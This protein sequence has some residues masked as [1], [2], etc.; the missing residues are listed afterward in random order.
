MTAPEWKRP[1]S[2]E[3]SSNIALHNEA[4]DR[5]HGKFDEKQIVTVFVG[6]FSKPSRHCNILVHG[7]CACATRESDATCA[8]PT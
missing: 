5:A 2:P 1:A 7:C 6:F 8:R 3:Y 4:F